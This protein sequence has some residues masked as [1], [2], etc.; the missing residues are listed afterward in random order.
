MKPVKKAVIPAA[1]LGTRFLPFTKATPK[2]ILPII[3]TPTIQMIVEEAKKSGIEEILIITNSHK[4][5]MENHFDYQYELEQKLLQ[6]GKEKECKMVREI[7]EMVK[8]FY[9]RQLEP[10]GLGDAILCAKAFVGNEPFAVLLGDDLMYTEENETPVLKQLIDAYEK[11]G[12]SVIG[13]HQVD[14]SLVHKYGIVTTDRNLD[15]R[16]FHMSGMIEKPQPTETPSRLA[17]MGRYVFTPEIFSYLETQTPGKG[18]E[19]QLTD[20]IVRMSE[21]YDVYAYDFMGRR[22]DIGDKFGFI[23]ATIDFALR[24]DDLKEQV[25]EY[26][27]KIT[28]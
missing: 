22:Y 28:K 16:T 4:Q 12:S 10:K 2:E 13:C 26:L 5:V 24:R 1:G 14:E 17:A 27:K 7:A 9:V 25:K 6:S 18:G 11:T 3:D 15:S 21:K 20:S 8:V 23:Q 19:I